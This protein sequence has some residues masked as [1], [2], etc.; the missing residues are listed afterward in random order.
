MALLVPGARADD[1]A[2]K[3]V[4]ACVAGTQESGGTCADGQNTGAEEESN[5]KKKP[6]FLRAWINL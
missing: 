5:E 2:R 6:K 1:G 4:S 3:D